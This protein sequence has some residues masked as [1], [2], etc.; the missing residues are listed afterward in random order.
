M[1][2]LKVSRE[3][4]EEGKR[5]DDDREGRRDGVDERARSGLTSKGRKKKKENEKTI[6]RKSIRTK[7][8]YV[9]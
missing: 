3:G 7:K 4:E 1:I 9:N 6:R 5:I 8:L 2:S